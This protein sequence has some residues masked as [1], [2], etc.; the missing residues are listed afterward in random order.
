MKRFLKKG[1]LI[2]IAAVLIICM[3]LYLPALFGKGESLT[4]IVYESG[5]ATHTVK[6]HDIEESYEIKITGGV[7]LVEKDAISY[8]YADCPDKICVRTGKLTKPGDTAACVPNKTV[9]TVI[10]EKKNSKIDTVTY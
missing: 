1:D 6:L 3:L 7:L 5:E 4:A 10:R 2:I 9:V 8:T